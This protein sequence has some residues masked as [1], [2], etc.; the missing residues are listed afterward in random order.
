MDDATQTNERCVFM[1]AVLLT[2]DTRDKSPKW[3]Q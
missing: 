1:A 2:C 3:Q